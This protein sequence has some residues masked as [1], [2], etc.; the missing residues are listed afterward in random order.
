MPLK[1]LSILI[2]TVL[3]GITITSCTDDKGDS[4][5]STSCT[6]VTETLGA[7]K[8]IQETIALINALP[9]PVTMECFLTSLKAPLSVFAVNN[10]F[11]AQPAV[12]QASPRIFI[13]QNKFV[14]SVVPGGVGR[15]LLEF[16]ELNI[17][18]ES[19][20]GE[21]EFPINET[22]T[23]EQILNQTTGTSTTSN[24]INCHSGE[25]KIDYKS[26]G[27][28][29]VSNVVAPNESQRVVQPYLKAQAAACNPAINKYRCDMLNAIYIKGQAQDA[30]FPF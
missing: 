17:G 12:D 16:S 21:L 30:A 28:L 22:V 19:Y 3:L 26:L 15:S 23:I 25:R 2:F 1:L 10:K 20:K 11:S 13:L 9:R 18:S 24:C 6:D 4:S 29:F 14:L 8:S 7:P 27:N 5:S